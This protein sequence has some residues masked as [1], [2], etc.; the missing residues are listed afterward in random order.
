MTSYSATAEAAW[1]FT[2]GAWRK[3]GTEQ[4]WCPLHTAHVSTP[5]GSDERQWRCSSVPRSLEDPPSVC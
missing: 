5:P 4:T 3:T 2:C 1:P